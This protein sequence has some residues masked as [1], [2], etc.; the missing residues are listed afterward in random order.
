MPITG[1]YQ[2]HVS[3]L[4]KMKTKEQF[5]KEYLDSHKRGGCLVPAIVMI[6]AGMLFLLGLCYAFSWFCLMLVDKFGN[7]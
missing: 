4:N 5:E 6:I 1:V 3:K 2:A 7:G